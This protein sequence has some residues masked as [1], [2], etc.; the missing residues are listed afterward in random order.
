MKALMYLGEQRLEIQE[1]PDPQGDFLVRILGATICGT[2]LKTFLKGHPLFK[3]P[4]IL[5]HEGVGQVIK[6]HPS[7]GF[8]PGDY[9]VVA[10]YGNCGSCGLCAQGLGELCAQKRFVPTGMFSEIISVPEDFVADGIIKLEKFDKAFALTEPLACVVCGAEKIDIQPESRLLV[11]GGG[12]MG[13][14]LARLGQA[15]GAQ[16][17]VSEPKDQRRRELERMHLPCAEPNQVQF[18]DF[19]RAAI[20]VNLPEVVSQVVAGIAPGAKVNVFA[21]LPAGSTLTLDAAAIHYREVLVTG[22]SGFALRHFHQAFRMISENPQAFGQLV[23]EE[24]PMEQAEDAFWRLSRGEAFK[25]MLQ[26]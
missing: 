1:L 16:V 2:D 3:P 22:S 4:T 12:P 13:A 7:T 5:G 8:R 11:V 20:A 17:L 14:L 24:L 15:L 9:C 19:D 26:P 6:A 21:G 10:P 23:T 18:V 25:V